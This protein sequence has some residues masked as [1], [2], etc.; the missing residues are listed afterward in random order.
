MFPKAAVSQLHACKANARES[1][2]NRDTNAPG[3]NPILK[4][5]GYMSENLTLNPLKEANLGVAQE[6]FSF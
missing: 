4:G 2:S 3:G 1:Q 5:R 6:F